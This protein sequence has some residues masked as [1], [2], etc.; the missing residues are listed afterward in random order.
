MFDDE[1]L[2]QFVGAGVEQLGAD[3]GGAPGVIRFE[4]EGRGEVACQ[5]QEVGFGVFAYLFDRQCAEAEV[6]AEEQAC[7]PSEDL[8]H[9]FEVKT[10]HPPV[11]FPPESGDSR[12]PDLGCSVDGEGIVYA[13]EGV[14]KVG[15]GVN[16]GRES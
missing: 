6:V 2:N 4:I 11:V 5:R 7:L 16:I 14:G 9:L 8:Y 3:T 12:R 1:I 15:D 13:E 10:L